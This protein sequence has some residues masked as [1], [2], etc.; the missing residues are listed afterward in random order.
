VPPA[1]LGS[2][3]FIDL[4]RAIM[5]SVCDEGCILVAP[6][7]LTIQWINVLLIS[8]FR[9]S[10]IVGGVNHHSRRQNSGK[11]HLQYSAGNGPRSMH[12]ILIMTI[13]YVMDGE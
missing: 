3:L 2:S 9:L 6:K 4:G 8:F 1:Q 10:W 7:Y 5:Y 11:P 12:C 13:L